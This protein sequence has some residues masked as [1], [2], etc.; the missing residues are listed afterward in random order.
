MISIITAVHN[1]LAMNKLFADSL[2]KYSTMPFELIIIDNASTDGSADFFESVGAKVIRNTQN[3]SYPYTQNQ[4]I[5][6]ATGNVFAFL[7]N[8]IIV[9]PNWDKLLLETLKVNA[10]D[11]VTSCGIEQVESKQAS[12]LLRRRWNYAKNFVNL[13][14][15]SILSLK[16]MH[17][18]MYGNWKKFCRK[19]D[20]D[21]HNKVKE[22]FVGHSVFCT[23]KVLDL[24]GLWDEKLQAADFDIYMRSKK[25]NLEFGDIK[26]C[27]IALNIFNHHYIRLTVR[28][29]PVPFADAD[30]IIK[31][32]DKW[33]QAERKRLL[34]DIEL[35]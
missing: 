30:N 29:K 24:I 6:I 10:L 8:D 11:L 35:I 16:L 4:G 26:P 25:R 12:I 22:G 5:K 9:C 3:F 18:L 7:N 28:S 19:R 17:K 20:A 31:F 34:K 1:Q 33:S 27:H 23:R 14:P 15:T 13:F 32:E 2:S 21:F